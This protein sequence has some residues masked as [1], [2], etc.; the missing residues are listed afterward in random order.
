MQ[1]CP[2][3]LLYVEAMWN[4]VPVPGPVPMGGIW[5]SATPAG[6]GNRKVPSE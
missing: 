5:L 1:A 4:Q 2:V 3:A 6:E